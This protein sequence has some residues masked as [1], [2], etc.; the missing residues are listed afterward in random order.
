MPAQW[1]LVAPLDTLRSPTYKDLQ[2]AV[3]QSLGHGREELGPR[4]IQP[5][6]FGSTDMG[7]VSY[8]VP[9]LHS[10]FVVPT[11]SNVARHNPNFAAAGATDE[12]HSITIKCA[13]DLAM[14]AFRV[15]TDD[16]GAMGAK[17]DFDEGLQLRIHNTNRE[18]GSPNYILGC[19]ANRE[20]ISNLGS[21]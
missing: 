17:A 4:E 19:S 12:A 5:K 14:L 20:P 7:I 6:A 11:P 15:L 10:A 21:R 3:S 13:K 8:E 16:K 18:D 1:L 9:G 2:R